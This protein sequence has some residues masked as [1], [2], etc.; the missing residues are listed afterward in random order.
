MMRRP[1]DIL[2]GIS[3]S[4]DE[5]HEDLSLHVL[6]HLFCLCLPQLQLCQPYQKPSKLIDR[7]TFVN[8]LC[9]NVHECNERGD[10]QEDLRLEL[11]Y[12]FPLLAVL[13]PVIK[14]DLIVATTLFNAVAL[15][16]ALLIEGVFLDILERSLFGNL[17]LHEIFA[18]RHVRE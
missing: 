4:D 17:T 2:G 16:E 6:D 3:Y 18:L 12:L 13:P 7:H 9:Q 8:D 5:R 10:Y 1:Y 15:H 14:D 11:F